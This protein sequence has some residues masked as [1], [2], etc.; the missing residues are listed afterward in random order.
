[1]R[2]PFGIAVH[3]ADG[4][5]V[6]AN[7]EFEGLTGRPATSIVGCELEDYLPELAPVLRPPLDEVIATRRDLHTEVST[8]S[9][10]GDVPVRS[11]SVTLRSIELED[12]TP[13]VALV[14][15]D[16]TER[17]AA[18]EALSASEMELRRVFESIDQG[19]C[20]AEIVTDA[21]GRPVD[22]RFLQVNP[23]FEE[24]TGLSDPVGRTAH[25][26]VPGL[27]QHW[28]DA[29]GRVALDGE[30]MRFE[31][32]SETLGRW[33]DVFAT[34]L[35]TPGRFAIV[36][37]DETARRIAEQAEAASAEQYRAMA[38]ELPLSMWV[39]GPD[40]QQEFV[41][42][43]YCEFF[44]V[45]REK[46][47]SNEWHV[48]V[49]P[50]DAGHYIAAF[51]RAVAE[52]G[53]F[54]EHVRV[55]DA[56]GAWRWL[57]SWAR[58]RFDADGTF[59]GHIGASADVTERITA[60]AALAES[61][62]FQRKVLDGLFSFVGLLDVDGTLLEANQVALDAI[63][64][65]LDSIRGMKFWDCPWWSY[66]EGIAA[67][68]REAIE[69][70]AAGR[71]VRYDVPIL[72]KD[73]QRIWIDFQLVP[74]RSDAGVVTHLV[75][76]GLDIS[77]RI[78]YEQERSIHL[79]NER[80]LRHR[81]ELLESHS[82][83]LASASDP[84]EI[85]LCT[86]AHVKQSVGAQLTAV[87]LRREQRVELIAG[88]GVRPEQLVGDIRLDE[89]LPGPLAIAANATIHLESRA[90][91]VTRF[92]RLV[93]VADGYEIESLVAIPMRSSTG[94][95]LGALVVAASGLGDLAGDGMALLRALAAQAG[96]ALERALL[97]EQVVEAQRR[98]HQIAV[99]LQRSLLP[100]RL[101]THP[102]VRIAARYHAAGD[103]MEVG[104]DWY[105]SFEWPT[106]EIGVIV[107][108]VAGHDLEAAVAMGR[109]RAAVAA[110]APTVPPDPSQL[111][112]ALQHVACGPDGTPFVTAACA[113]V[114]PVEGV[115]H[116]A[117]A[118]HPPP[119]VIRRD[120]VD[121]LL[122]DPT[123]PLGTLEVA[124]P[125]AHRMKLESGDCVLLY[126]D[127]LIERRGET[128]DVGFERLT[129]A[130]SGA[131]TDDIDR[132]LDRLLVDLA[133]DAVD[134][135]IVI[136]AMCW[137]SAS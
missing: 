86:V 63:G 84:R 92:P 122:S 47:R 58:P 57:E 7:E 8:G 23:L 101:V 43:T 64:V 137:T 132:L 131:S 54:H 17:N 16:I 117:S 111:L 14:I 36:F 61:M 49:H 67:D 70:A 97:H 102:H 42:R 59:L 123:P 108:D 81:A 80:A 119:L 113:V 88:S 33:F 12:D 60:E 100:D 32:G 96:P 69:Q 133:D 9:S 126:S 56:A 121:W 98:E 73:D 29:Y 91:I 75:P 134:D 118:G 94:S 68:L 25:E 51:D 4:R 48:L 40:G 65:T 72:D 79:A 1:M 10:S 26:L 24:M 11:W 112:E 99:R 20:V 45:E 39:H 90:D 30:S 52:R 114:D 5:C 110:L 89:N 77:A 136:V 107:G 104:G 127:G 66:D 105:D 85:A 55:A 106:G 129:S 93:D 120:G 27:E 35:A 116:Y 31:Q 78:A 38:D 34:P 2:A 41:N 87:N 95:A 3:D 76:S 13:G 50:D 15:E 128:I 130:C 53:P 74:V 62:G 71:V 83:D 18:V 19:F 22:Y 82:A 21:D 135:D 115:V 124:I 46:M 6:L 125:D 28:V 37:R 103:R 44:G 109:V